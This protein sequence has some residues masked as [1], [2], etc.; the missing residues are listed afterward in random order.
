MIVT[1]SPVR[2]SY[3][4]TKA[5][6]KLPELLSLFLSLYFTALYPFKSKYFSI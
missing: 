1:F 5:C 3:K 2:E 4:T 6:K